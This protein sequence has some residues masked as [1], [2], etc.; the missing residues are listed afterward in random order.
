MDKT[1]LG[2]A[3]TGK[4]FREAR[5]RRCLRTSPVRVRFNSVSPPSRDACPDTRSAYL[6]RIHLI[7]YLI[8]ERQRARNAPEIARVLAQENM[9]SSSMRCARAKARS[10]AESYGD[11]AQPVGSAVLHSLQLIIRRPL[12]VER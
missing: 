10:V 6:E 11:R 8:N 9:H 5:L 2:A 3:W 12:L 4:K 7:L 1:R